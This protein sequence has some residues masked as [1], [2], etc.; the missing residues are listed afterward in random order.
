MKE[1]GTEEKILKAAREA[2]T[3]KGMHGARMQE[4]AD[5]AGINK[6][7][8]H[9]YYRSK[10]QLF[11]AVFQSILGEMIPKLF[12][13]FI[14]DLSLEDKI[15]KLTDIYIEFLKK[16]QDLPLFVLFELQQH[17]ERLVSNMN[18]KSLNQFEKIQ[19]QLDEEAEKGNIKP[20]K[21]PHFIANFISMMVFPF[22][23]RP[24]MKTV[25]QINQD[26]YEQLMEE[27]KTEIPRFMINALKP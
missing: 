24:M 20:I 14:S 26:Q 23:A 22:V 11:L 3:Q 27:R 12:P 21:L 2:F 18:L 5:K 25:L 7:L 8:L 9:Y 15:Y 1:E 19:K 4:I 17:P 16:N 10:D 6:A 13:V